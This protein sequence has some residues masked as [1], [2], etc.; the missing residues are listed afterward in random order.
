MGLRAFFGSILRCGD[1][2]FLG[3]AR[4]WRVYAR[5]DVVFARIRMVYARFRY[6]Q[7]PRFMSEFRYLRANSS[8]YEQISETYEQIAKKTNLSI[9]KR[10]LSN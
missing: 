5:I 4:S 3:Y 6:E 1:V 7:I 2:R 9:K 10:G 8:I